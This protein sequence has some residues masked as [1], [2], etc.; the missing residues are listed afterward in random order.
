MFA[1][2]FHSQRHELE[3]DFVIVELRRPERPFEA[4]RADEP[5][6]DWLDLVLCIAAPVAVAVAVLLLFRAGAQI[7]AA[8]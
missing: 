6:P 2:L 8:L 7:T 3:D 1:S 5:L 4:P